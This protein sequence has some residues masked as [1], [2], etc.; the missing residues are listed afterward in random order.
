MKAGWSKAKAEEW[1]RKVEEGESLFSWI[2]HRTDEEPPVELKDPATENL[3]RIAL[4]WG[5]RREDAGG[6]ASSQIESTVEIQVAEYPLRTHFHL[7]NKAE[8]AQ[9]ENGLRNRSRTFELFPAVPIK[10]DGSSQ[11]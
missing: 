6:S 2:L 11:Q 5:R 9:A 3:F 8:E 7:F 1:S 10:E 4:V